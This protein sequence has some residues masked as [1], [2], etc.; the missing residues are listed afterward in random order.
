MVYVLIISFILHLIS[1]LFM[2]ILFQRQEKQQIVDQKKI[3]NEMEDMLVA[4]T[5]EM[6]EN[7]ERI[8]NIVLKRSKEFTVS[9]A[10]NHENKDK[11]QEKDFADESIIIEKASIRM[12][13]EDDEYE[14]YSP[15]VPED[16][17]K[18]TTSANAKI[19]SLHQEGYSVQEIAQQLNM[20]AGEVEL[21]LKFYKYT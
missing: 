1:F 6:K 7:N 11:I 19:L 16:D 9:R 20:G 2:I 17:S 4:Y 18:A 13:D 14:A 5:A 15:P 21:F 10:K 12:E 3:L 8:A